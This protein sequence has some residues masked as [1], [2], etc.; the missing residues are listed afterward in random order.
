MTTSIVLMDSLKK[1]IESCVKDF[2]LKTPSGNFKSPAVYQQYIPIP[3]K[4]TRLSDDDIQELYPNLVIRYLGEER[5]IVDICIIAGTY[6]K[7]VNVGWRDTLNIIN[8]IKIDLL[9]A[10]MIDLT[11]SMV[12]E[13]FVVD[14]PQEQ[15]NPQWVGAAFMQFKLPV[16]ENEMNHSFL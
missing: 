15:K 11:F 13:S 1:R 4:T 2:V 8:R 3:E 7:D 16:I 5:N 14:I 6:E 12:E 9:K 10:P